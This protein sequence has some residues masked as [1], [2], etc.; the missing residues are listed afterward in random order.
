M[1]ETII[2]PTTGLP[3]LPED[4][5]W[6]LSKYSGGCVV[7]I[8]KTLRDNWHPDYNRYFHVGRDSETRDVPYVYRTWYGRKRPGIR[9][10]YRDKN[11]G[12]FENQF[13]FEGEVSEDTVLAMTTK[14]LKKYKKMLNTK[15]LM[16][17]YPPKKLTLDGGLND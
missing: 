11:I 13:E 8:R 7:N 17:D 16:G 2:D 10:E 15:R 6:R 1:T 3:Q 9:K 12:V 5:F 14:T 4:H